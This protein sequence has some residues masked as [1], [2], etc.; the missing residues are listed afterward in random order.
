MLVRRMRDH[1][2]HGMKILLLLGKG[3]AESC[4]SRSSLSL[5][6]GKR[7][8]YGSR[9]NNCSTVIRNHRSGTSGSS[10]TDSHCIICIPLNTP[11]A[12]RIYGIREGSFPRTLSA[13]PVHG[14]Q[15]TDSTAAMGPIPLLLKIEVDAVPVHY[16]S[17]ES[18]HT[19][20]LERWP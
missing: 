3:R 2:H 6:W 9:I 12:V 20:L 15:G 13:Q 8:R 1:A 16:P 19:R 11:R 4:Y 5:G 18:V 14:T 10:L 7:K 17:G